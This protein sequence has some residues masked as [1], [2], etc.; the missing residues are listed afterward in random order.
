MPI[1]PP[2]NRKAFTTF[3]SCVRAMRRGGAEDP[4]AICGKW[5]SET[6]GR[7][8]NRES[9][10]VGRVRI[11]EDRIASRLAAD[12]VDRESRV[13][14]GVR[15]LGR[16]SINGRVYSDHAMEQVVQKYDG[17]QVF[18]DHD[19]GERKLRE[20]FGTIRNPRLQGQGD[21]QA[22]VGDLHYLQS[23]P[24]SEQVL[25]AV[26]RFP[27]SFG[28]S[29]DAEGSVSHRDGRAI[30]QEVEVVHSIDIVTRPATNAGIFESQE[31]LMPRK[32][33]KQIVE[34]QT[35][36]K[37]SRRSPL[38]GILKEQLG[39]EIDGAAVAE[40]PVD[41]ADSADPSEM[42][43]EALRTLVMS[44]FDDES[45]DQQQTLDKIRQVLQMKSELP[46]GNG[47]GSSGE[48]TANEAA[49]ES[50]E[51]RVA[52]LERRL[53]E[54]EDR[55]K[56]SKYLSDQGVAI[57]EARVRTL[58]AADQGDV[59]ELVESFKA[60]DSKSGR[61]SQSLTRPRFSPPAI[62]FDEEEDE[63]S[64][65]KIAESDS[66]S[67]RFHRSDRKTGV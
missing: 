56:V 4:R 28:L 27:R 16:E 46:S 31:R 8:R 41:G 33:I 19:Q 17:V 11:S 65:D 34:Q 44:I 45:L 20:F 55:E 62:D 57:N 61:N 54:T 13:I 64:Y 12:R 2:E 52:E 30:V 36:L 9:V 40:M 53:Q 24:L 1:G 6:E 39:N 32:T 3:D 63:A 10:T 15:I 59:K 60:A 48:E 7:R 5:Q 50:A 38:Y 14:H 42:T 35:K 21:E 49:S 67:R 23:H 18:I 26:E 37:K 58:I 29:H 66:L 22:V 43:K 51:K 25:E 47:G